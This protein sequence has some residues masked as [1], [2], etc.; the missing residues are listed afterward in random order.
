MLDEQTQCQKEKSSCKRRSGGPFFRL[1]AKKT[2]VSELFC[3]PDAGRR[4]ILSNS[5]RQR[6]ILEK[7]MLQSLLPFIRP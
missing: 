6:K 3:R 4:G 1:K 7:A 2:P 5:L